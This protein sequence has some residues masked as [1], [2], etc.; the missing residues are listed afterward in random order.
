[1]QFSSANYTFNENGGAA[2][3]TVTR[4]GGSDGAVGVSYATANGTAMAGSDYTGANGTL[5]WNAA[6]SDSKTF[7]IPI[8][9]DA[10][11]E[12]SETVNLILTN[13]TGGATL[14]TPNPATLTIIDNEPCSYSITPTSQNIVAAG[15]S[16][17]ASVTTA[18]GCAWTAASNAAWLTIMNG[19]SGSGN[20]TVNYSAAANTGSG[21]R[22]GTLTI[23]GKTLTIIQTAATSIFTVNSTAT[24]MMRLTATAFAKRRR[25]LDKPHDES[26]QFNRR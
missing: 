24:V 6:D 9:D 17:S 5:N 4:T 8:L 12:G 19:S 25:D 3:I 26:H 16:Y 18:S 2:T 15:G 23:A 13:A 10:I 7:S 22:T 21:G 14:G 11:S 1:M 20:G